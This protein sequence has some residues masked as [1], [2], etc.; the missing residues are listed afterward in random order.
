MKTNSKILLKTRISITMA[1]SFVLLK[2][3]QPCKYKRYRTNFLY[4]Q[5]EEFVLQD[6]MQLK[7]LFYELV[8]PFDGIQLTSKRNRL[9]TYSDCFY[10]HEL[11][12]W[13]VD[14]DKSS[15]RRQAVVIGQ[16][17]LDAKFLQCL[18]NPTSSPFKDDYSL[19]SLRDLTRGESRERQDTSRRASLYPQLS[20]DEPNW[21]Q[22]LEQDEVLGN[23]GTLNSKLG[24]SSQYCFHIQHS[25]IILVKNW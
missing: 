17:L 9:R 12:G 22:E 25:A 14:R 16:A 24:Y 6:S 23:M 2:S 1:L 20:D 4:A 5:I 19:Y 7:E 13:L 10:G 21:V 15:D 11:V 18:T 3:F 8:D